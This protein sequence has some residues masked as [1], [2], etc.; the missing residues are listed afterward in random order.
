MQR[1]NSSSRHVRSQMDTSIYRGVHL[2][3]C[4]EIRILPRVNLEQPT[5]P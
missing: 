2:N 4:L 3:W 5:D 1:W